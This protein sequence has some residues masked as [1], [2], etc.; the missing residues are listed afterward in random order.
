[1]LAEKMRNLED[2]ARKLSVD[3]SVDSSSVGSG[4]VS[5]VG[6]EKEGLVGREVTVRQ[7]ELTERR[8]VQ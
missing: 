7:K 1:M 4:F 3:S 5:L 6:R 8:T 2:M